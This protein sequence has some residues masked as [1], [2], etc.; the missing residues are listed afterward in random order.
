MSEITW[1]CPKDGNRLLIDSTNKGPG[2]PACH[3]CQ[4]A[5]VQVV[6]NVDPFVVEPLIPGLAEALAKNDPELQQEPHA[7][8]GSGEW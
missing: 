1:Q 3:A 6:E 8:D 7:L 4:S 2:V 5:M